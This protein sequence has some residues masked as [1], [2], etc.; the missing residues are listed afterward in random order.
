MGIVQRFRRRQAQQPSR[1]ELQKQIDE[2]YFSATEEELMP[3]FDQLAEHGNEFRSV[4]DK[5]FFE[6]RCYEGHDSCDAELWYRSHQPVEIISGPL[7]D[8]APPTEE[9]MNVFGRTKVERAYSGSPV[10]YKVRF[11]DGFEYDTTEDELL[12]S[13]EEYVRPDPPQKPGQ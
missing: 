2:I 10:I 8:G 11:A 3:L 6:Y 7:L 5:V 4:G 13:E 12:D 9:S 1:E